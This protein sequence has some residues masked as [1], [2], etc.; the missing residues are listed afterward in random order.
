M[1]LLDHVEDLLVP[2]EPNVMVGNCHRLKQIM[3]IICAKFPII[4]NDKLM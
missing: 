2:V 1:Y 4:K 3:A